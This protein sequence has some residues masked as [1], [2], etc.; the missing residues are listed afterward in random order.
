MPLFMRLASL[1]ER[2]GYAV[3]I[4]L[5]P[6]HLSNW[7]YAP[8]A[9]LFKNSNIMGTG[10]GLSLQ[11]LY[12]LECVASAFEPNAIFIIGNAFGWSTIALALLF[13]NAH[14]LAIDNATEGAD[15]NKGIKLT[16]QIAKEENLRVTVIDATSPQHVSEVLLLHL[17]Q[18]IDLCLV[19][20]MHTN[21]Q[22]TV[23]YQAVKSFISTY[24][25]LLFH[26][27]IELKMEASFD[28]IRQDWAGESCL[29]HRTPS[30]MGACIGADAD[31][32]LKNVVR[33]F[34]EPLFRT[35]VASSAPRPL[36]RRIAGRIKRTF[37]GTH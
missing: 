19:D 27:V 25:L 30:G 36:V 29:L 18:P 22:Q 6:H 4:G 37:V 33:A 3:R 24:G 26:D 11:E 2:Y 23:D 7:K 10:G 32:K 14:V 17:K 35:A 5:N 16:R 21:E 31:E 28:G 1:Y 15:A 8:Y 34:S 13:P 9:A 20:G 12:F